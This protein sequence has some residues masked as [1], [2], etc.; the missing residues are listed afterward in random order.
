MKYLLVAGRLLFV[1]IFIITSFTQFKSQT[2]A[3]AAFKGVP[4][5]SV[6]VPFSG[7]MEILGGLSI[8]LGYRARIGALLIILFLIPVTFMFHPFWTIQD[9]MA[10]QTEMSNF[11][12]N[13]S[14]MGG[15]FIIAYFGSGELSLDNKLRKSKN[16]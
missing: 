2:I 5:A 1:S 3:F 13:I 4:L 7:I 11:F 15:A 6:L 16:R 12:E 10:R 9:Q 14:M 8:L